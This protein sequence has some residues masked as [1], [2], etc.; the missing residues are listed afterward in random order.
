MSYILARIR[1]AGYFAEHF[2]LNS[3]DYGVPQD[4]VRVYIVGFLN[5]EC[6]RKF[7]LPAPHNSTLRL[8]DILQGNVGQQTTTA[9]EIPT[10]LFGNPL[11]DKRRYRKLS[12]M[13]DFFLF[14]DIRN[15][16][17]TIHSWDLLPDNGQAEADLFADAAQLP[18]AHLWQTGWQPFCPDPFAGF[19]SSIQQRELETLVAM[20]ILKWLNMPIMS[21]PMLIW[22]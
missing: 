1:Q 7:S 18:Q 17:T 19:D 16:L 8:A 9:V 14:N 11:V 13:N 3:S 15:G 12:G 10:D 2:V 20:G 5:K 22:F 21:N 6:L 4:R